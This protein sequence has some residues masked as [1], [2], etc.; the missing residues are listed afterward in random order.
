M[1]KPF[2][3]EAEAFAAEM[4]EL[5]KVYKDGDEPDERYSAFT[6][7]FSKKIISETALSI[8]H[9]QYNDAYSAL[10]IVSRIK[11]YDGEPF[12]GS[13]DSWLDEGILHVLKPKN[14]LKFLMEDGVHP[15]KLITINGVTLTFYE[16]LKIFEVFD[17]L[18]AG[19]AHSIFY[20][21]IYTDDWELDNMSGA[22]GYN[23]IQKPR[24]V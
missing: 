19:V 2:T 8:S 12:E 3:K 11:D 17:G 15:G 9:E 13:I 23:P 20:K 16:A 22:I 5:I 18:E 21:G 6:K 7:E 1:N 14:S 4:V 10:S 24:E